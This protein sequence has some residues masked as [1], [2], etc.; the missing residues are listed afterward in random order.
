M[1]NPFSL[2]DRPG[3]A[4]AMDPAQTR[5]MAKDIVSRSLVKA[6]FAWKPWAIGLSAIALVAL[7]VAG[8]RKHEQPVQAV[9]EEPTIAAPAVTTE[10]PIIATE[11]P[12]IVPSAIPTVAPTIAIEPKPEDLLRTANRLRGDGKWT[13]A[14]DTYDRAAR[15]R[16]TDA[17][18][19][20][21]VA[22]AQLRLE[23]LSDP[24]GARDRFL[25]ALKQKP[26]GPLSEDC[27]IG[28]A[29]AYRALGDV[30][31]ERSALV[32]YQTKYP[33]G[34]AASRAKSRLEQIGKSP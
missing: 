26:D 17:S 5:A 23:H 20:A 18:Y 4:T 34:L 33:N 30:A 21:L 16:G 2:D 29:D 9:H 24:K 1:K 25:D 19:A 3:P 32:E 14:R 11:A 6:P 28:L 13:E 10:P 8:T 15:A 7:I 31:S 27:R 22:S 12:A